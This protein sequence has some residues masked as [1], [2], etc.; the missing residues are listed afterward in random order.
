MLSV[1]HALSQ[2]GSVGTNPFSFSAP[3]SVPDSVP[4]ERGTTGGEGGRQPHHMGGPTRSSGVGACEYSS[5]PARPPF[6]Q[7]VLSVPVSV[8]DRSAN[9]SDSARDLHDS[10]NLGY[11]PSHLASSGL[12][13]LRVAGDSSVVHAAPS[14]GSFSFLSFV[15]S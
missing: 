10:A 1:L 14:G 3:S 7:S 9:V 15:S 11:P 8:R 2:S 5:S 13:Q 4:Q 6:V 12:D